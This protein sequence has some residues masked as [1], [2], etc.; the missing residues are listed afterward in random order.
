M[1]VYF[2]CRKKGMR[3]LTDSF[4]RAPWE[5]VPFV[6]SMFII[7]LSL[8]KA[9]ATEALADLLSHGDPIVTFGSTSF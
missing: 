7:V 9:G 5:I 2:A 4:R 3:M 8:E 1:A 6:L